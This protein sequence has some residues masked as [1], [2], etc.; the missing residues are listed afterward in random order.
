MSQINSGDVFIYTDHISDNAS[1]IVNELKET[2]K[3]DGSSII[4]G[5]ALFS[6][7]YSYFRIY[8][9][10]GDWWGYYVDHDENVITFTK[11]KYLGGNNGKSY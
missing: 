1:F 6:E 8:N 11:L 3:V 7:W 10:N 5:W 9:D 2:Y 4:S